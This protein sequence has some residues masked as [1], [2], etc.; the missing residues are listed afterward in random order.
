MGFYLVPLLE[1]YF[2][3]ISFCLLAVV[4]GFFSAGCRVPLVYAVHSLVG[5][6]ASCP[7]GGHG[8]VKECVQR[9]LWA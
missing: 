8:C 6:A 4:C 1:T 2:S 7:S 3:V 9:W 5:R